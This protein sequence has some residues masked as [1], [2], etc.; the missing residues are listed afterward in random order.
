[1]I[2]ESEL[3]APGDRAELLAPVPHG[4]RVTGVFMDPPT[5]AVFAVEGEPVVITAGEMLAYSGLNQPGV[6]V[7]I[8]HRG[9]DRARFRAEVDLAPDLDAVKESIGRA[10]EDAWK[11][12][13]D[14]S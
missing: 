6:R 2:I 9:R 14:P 5:A 8:V 13:G 10:V 7:A 4:R 1:M 3:M 11:R 12:G